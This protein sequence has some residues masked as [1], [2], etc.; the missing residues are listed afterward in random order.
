VPC[1]A[2]GEL[3]NITPFRGPMIQAVSA[4][5]DCFAVTVINRARFSTRFT[6]SPQLD[7]REVI[8]LLGFASAVLSFG[9]GSDAAGNPTSP[10]GTTAAST[11][12]SCAVTPTETIGPYPSHESLI[13]GDIREGKSGTPLALTITVVSSSNKLWRGRGSQ[14]RNLAVRRGWQ[15]LRVRNPNRP[16]LPS[17]HSDDRRKWSGDL[18]HH[19]S[20]VV[21]GPCDSHPC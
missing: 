7:R 9:C 15:L 8:S 2:S 5:G 12:A 16:D 18:H 3:R 1:F 21:P 19:L 14:R 6:V 4:C 17:R 13:R 20:G 10:E 11:N